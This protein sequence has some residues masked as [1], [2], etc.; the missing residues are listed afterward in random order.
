M[1]S[2]REFI[3]SVREYAAGSSEKIERVVESYGCDHERRV[4]VEFSGG[5]IIE[6]LTPYYLD[7]DD[8]CI[9]EIE[10]YGASEADYCEDRVATLSE[11]DRFMVV[12]CGIVS[13]SAAQE[14][15]EVEFGDGYGR[16]RAEYAASIGF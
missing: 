11:F 16:M 15:T 12:D 5:A 13:A 2:Y 4:C 7:E 9:D 1:E 14:M 10:V 3:A 8:D 6:L